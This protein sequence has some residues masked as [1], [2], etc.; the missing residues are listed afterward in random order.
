MARVLTVLTLVVC[1]SG[2]DLL[3]NIFGPKPPKKQY[4]VTVATSGP[5]SVIRNPNQ[6]RYEAGSQVQLTAEPQPG[7][8]FSSW[9]GAATGSQNPV[10]LTVNSN[11]SVTA[12]FTASL[13][14]L[15]VVK[16][17]IGSG[18]VTG[19][20][21]NCGSDCT[22]MLGP[23]SVVL[24]AVPASGAAFDSWTG[25]D[26]V[27]ANACTV[28]MA[29]DRTVT[30]QFTLTL[31]GPQVT[32]PATSSSGSYQVTIKCVSAL[33]STS[34]VVQEAPTAA[35]T[36]PTQSFFANSPDPLVLSY[37]GKAAG[38]YCYRAAYSVPN[39]GNTACVTVAT[40][41]TA[42]LRISNASSYD[43]ID[44]RLN[45]TQQIA[46]PNGILA[47]QS[48]DFVFT[49]SGTVSFILGN[50][51]YNPNQSRDVWFTLTGSTTVTLGQTTLVTFNNPTMGELLSYGTAQNWDGLF[52]DA[53]AN[54]YYARFRFT[55][56]NS[57]WTFYV[58]TASCFGGTTCNFAQ[59]GSGTVRLVSWPRY[60]SIVTF[61]FGPG[62]TQ[63]SIMY[64]FASFTYRNGPA[65]WPII[66]YGRQ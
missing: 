27:S 37:T 11:L 35:F 44:A 5:G 19:S 10:T 45:S 9:S 56:S 64:P 13:M 62:S 49:T 65:S 4:T 63:A 57:G 7:N 41:A 66:E 47:G 43:I 1:L 22:E 53:G 31:S 12:S 36:N 60:S 55:K 26:N 34:I 23:G 18:T 30:A 25:C 21:I 51:F 46:Y 61:D 33:C 40:P 24:T 38:T 8:V 50:G 48:A 39:W 29:S 42:I 16:A 54:P 2:C 20:G 17:G 32:V 58:S 52:F 59:Q 6:G 15:T 14:K 3:Q 28:N